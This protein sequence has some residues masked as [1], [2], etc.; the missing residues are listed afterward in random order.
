MISYNIYPPVVCKTPFGV[1][2][3]PDVYS[4]NNGSSA[5]IHSHSPESYQIGII[6]IWGTTFCKRRIC[7]E[8]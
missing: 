7:N 3:D 2:V 6:E 5:S 4:I 1:P 8:H